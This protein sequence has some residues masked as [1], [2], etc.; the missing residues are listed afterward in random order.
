MAVTPA[1]NFGSDM[2]CRIV[3]H[4]EW[5][6]LPVFSVPFEVSSTY[7]F[8]GVFVTATEP[9]AAQQ[10]NNDVCYNSQTNRFRLSNGSTWADTTLATITTG[11][12]FALGSIG[13]GNLTIDSIGEVLDYFNNPSNSYDFTTTRYIYYESSI[14]EV[15]EAQSTVLDI[16]DRNFQLQG[17]TLRQT[18]TPINVATSKGD[19]SPTR[20]QL[21]QISV[22]GD[23]TTL[24]YNTHM[25]TWLKML[26]GV[27]LSGTN[28]GTGLTTTQQINSQSGVVL[29]AASYSSG[30]TIASDRQPN[31]LLPEP[32]N[33]SKLQIIFAGASNAGN[34]TI[35][36]EDQNG[37]P[38]EEYHSYTAIPVSGSPLITEYHYA[39]V[40]S[41]VVSGT[42]GGTIAITL[43]GNRYKHAL[44]IQEKLDIG[45]AF[46]VVKGGTGEDATAVVYESAI[47][48]GGTLT[49]ADAV[50]L[51]LN[52]LGRK[53][54]FRR[55]LG[56][57]GVIVP[58]STIT[59]ADPSGEVATNWGMEVRIADDTVTDI[60]TNDDYVYPMSAATF[61]L[62]QVLDYPATRY[63]K[64]VYLPRPGRNGN[65]EIGA[66]TTIDYSKDNDFDSA[67]YGVPQKVVLEAA[68][69]PYGGA[70]TGLRITL[71]HTIL[72][73]FPDPS[74]DGQGPITQD[75]SFAAFK[76]TNG[77]V[78]MEFFNSEAN[79]AFL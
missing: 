9:A 51:T 60:L 7:K 23:M 53:A 28:A 77:E 74:P 56:A 54:Y 5:G 64:S 19:S 40:D 41:V 59:G 2:F 68:S 70:Y 58:K 38:L 45:A 46:Q 52:F 57:G 15:R 20:Q 65:R 24:I 75:L 10:S 12:V 43:S 44:L 17:V 29:P 66:T 3:P 32:F 55:G 22:E 13:T 18:A 27:P 37:L 78:L 61:T 34:I 47:C 67:A 42:T 14:S 69:L 72:T 11:T 1:E 48:T 6:E 79:A 73:D 21:G 4:S 25:G 16:I 26:M 76:D 71:F 50:T 33:A 35:K 36:G 63:H 62:N 30:V 39:K 49:L 8:V 31:A